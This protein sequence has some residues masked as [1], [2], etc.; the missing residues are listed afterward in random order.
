MSKFFFKGNQDKRENHNNVGY[1]PKGS[2]KQGSKK[3]PLELIVTSEQRKTEVETLLEE[4]E[5]FAT[6]AIDSTD[7]AEE[8]IVGLTGILNK[9]KTVTT[10]KTPNRNDLCSCG[11]GKKYKKCCG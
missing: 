10:E 7:D 11:S 1:Q 8:N 3:Y 5:L 2:L 9:P 6:I 4:N